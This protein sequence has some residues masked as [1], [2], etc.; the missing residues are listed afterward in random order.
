MLHWNFFPLPIL[1]QQS[2]LSTLQRDFDSK[3]QIHPLVPLMRDIFPSLDQYVLCSVCFLIFEA[4]PGV[5]LQREILNFPPFFGIFGWEKSA[6]NGFSLQIYEKYE[7]MFLCKQTAPR[8][9]NYTHRQ[10]RTVLDTNIVCGALL[11]VG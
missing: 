5:C 10:V 2:V 4:I 9:C 7:I 1:K 8:Y 3:I 11:I 6:E